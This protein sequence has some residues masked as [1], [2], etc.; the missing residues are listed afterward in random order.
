MTDTYANEAAFGVG[1]TEG[2]LGI[3]L[4]PEVGRGPQLLE[5]GDGAP[6]NCH[7]GHRAT[8]RLGI[9]VKS[10]IEVGD[11]GRGITILTVG[12][13]VGRNGGKMLALLATTIIGRLRVVGLAG[14]RLPLGWAGELAD[15]ARL[16]GIG[17]G[18]GQRLHGRV[19]LG[20]GGGLLRRVQVDGTATREVRLVMRPHGILDA[21]VGIVGI[22][23]SD[24][25][26]AVAHVGGGNG[27]G[28]GGG[29]GIVVDGGR[30]RSS[31]RLDGDAA[32]ELVVFVSSG[33]R[34]LAS[35]VPGHLAAAVMSPR[36]AGR[37]RVGI[38]LPLGIHG[39]RWLGGLRAAAAQRQQ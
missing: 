23:H 2:R 1:A 38:R 35:V 18:G 8:R 4:G 13:R 6:S 31:T 25:A 20:G 30:G 7:G 9:Q 14:G 32:V 21:G 19:S 28:N 33:R 34:G 10:S 15:G 36:G 17:R 39:W 27:G 5:F 22:M 37:G 26:V 12:R 11:C 3:D 29:G 24:V 16:G